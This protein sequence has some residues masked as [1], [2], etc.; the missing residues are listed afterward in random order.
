MKDK[1]N[2]GET[3]DRRDGQQM[4]TRRPRRKAAEADLKIKHWH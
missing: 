1:G 3:E 2:T 4:T